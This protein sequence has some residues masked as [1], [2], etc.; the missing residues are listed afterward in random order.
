MPSTRSM[1]FLAAVVLVTAIGACGTDK[2]TASTPRRTAFCQ[3]ETDINDAVRGAETSADAIAALRQFQP[4]MAQWIADAPA[5]MKANAQTL[6]DAATKT[7]ASDNPTD[8]ATA[9][10][11]AAGT[12]IDGYCG[13]TG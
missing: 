10:V 2:Q 7:I 13:I 9:G 8:L 1:Q 5:E 6:V 12:A 3:F 11:D 4:R